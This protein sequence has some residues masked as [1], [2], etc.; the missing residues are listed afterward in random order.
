MRVRGS[1][2]AL[3]ERLF[4]L[5]FAVE[6]AGG[7]GVLSSRHEL[8]TFVTRAAAGR[9]ARDADLVCRVVADRPLRCGDP[10]AGPFSIEL[11]KVESISAGAA[12]L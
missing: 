2:D 1:P 9:R 11:F 5:G 10:G 12:R 3:P 6:R 7:P 4:L 8:A